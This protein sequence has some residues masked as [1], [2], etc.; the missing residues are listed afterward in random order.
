[1]LQIFH[2]SAFLIDKRPTNENN[3]PYN[4]VINDSI[5]ISDIDEEIDEA[6]IVEELVQ[7]DE[8]E[9]NQVTT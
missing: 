9:D 4:T 3:R 5:D 2:Q 7:S 6:V 8:L 1:M